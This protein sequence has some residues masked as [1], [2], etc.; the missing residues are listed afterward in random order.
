[1]KSGDYALKGLARKGFASPY[2]AAVIDDVCSALLVRNRG[3]C[4]T[5]IAITA[6][7]RSPARYRERWFGE[8]V[9]MTVVSLK[10]LSLCAGA[11]PIVMKSPLPEAGHS[12]A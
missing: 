1:L 6:P 10:S 9:E 4:Q 12:T 2:A 7:N 8:C 3:V 5:G 11:M